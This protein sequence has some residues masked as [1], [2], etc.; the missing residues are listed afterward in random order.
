MGLKIGTAYKIGIAVFTPLSL[1]INHD[2]TMYTHISGV[3]D[4][5]VSFELF[6]FLTAGHFNPNLGP[7]RVPPPPLLSLPKACEGGGWCGLE[8]VRRGV[9]CLGEREEVLGVCG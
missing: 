8:S 3:H 6:R 9:M 7:P 4:T 1:G 2:M 5:A